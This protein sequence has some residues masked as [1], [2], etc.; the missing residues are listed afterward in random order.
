MFGLMGKSG[1]PTKPGA[2]GGQME[3]AGSRCSRIQHFGAHCAEPLGRAERLQIRPRIWE[4]LLGSRKSAALF[5][6]AG[7]RARADDL[8][9]EQMEAPRF[10]Y[11]G[12]LRAAWG[13]GRPSLLPAEDLGDAVGSRKTCGCPSRSPGKGSGRAADAPEFGTLAGVRPVKRPL[14]GFGPAE[15]LGDAVWVPPSKKCRGVHVVAKGPAE[16]W[17]TPVRPGAQC[18]TMPG[19]C[20]ANGAGGGRGVGRKFYVP[21]LWNVESINQS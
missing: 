10:L 18:P 11:Y 14:T 7:G 1:G 9:R 2:G 16:G 4:M 20:R 15:D 8:L 6:E 19:K 12:A 3:R 5:H 17:G 13:R 21:T